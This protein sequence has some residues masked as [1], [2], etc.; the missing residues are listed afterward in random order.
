MLAATSKGEAV[1]IYKRIGK[2]RL[3]LSSFPLAYT[4]YYFTQESGK[5]FIEKSFNFLQPDR[6]ILWDIY[7]HGEV[8]VSTNPLRFV[9]GNNAL[10]YSLY[11]S[12]IAALLFIMFEGKRKQRIIPIIEPVANNSL[13]FIKT[14]SNLYFAKGNHKNIADKKIVYF[15][16]YIKNHYYIRTSDPDFKSRLIAKSGIDEARV[17]HLLKYI[18]TV[19]YKSS[20]SGDDLIRLNKLIE[21][22]LKIADNMQNEMFENKIDLSVVANSITKIKDEVRKIIVGQE[23]MVEL[24]LASILADGHVLIEGVPGVAKT[25]TS[26]CLQEP[27][28]LTSAGY[29]L[30]L[31]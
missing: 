10:R 14:V 24:L 22:F 1:V 12:M 28:L 30:L 29:N 20:L 21:D 19:K 2:G 17:N 27:F 8:V 4:N 3:F 15:F 6:T 9:L 31:I 16:D 18:D 13:E 25:L 23:T 11:L 5:S 26:K 7:Y